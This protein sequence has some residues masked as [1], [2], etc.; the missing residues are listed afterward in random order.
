MHYFLTRSN[1][2][3]GKI[4]NTKYIWGLQDNYLNC[5]YLL[6][7]YQGIT[8]EQFIFINGKTA[9]RRKLFGQF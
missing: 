9:V 8:D 4:M 6:F 3:P 2:L 5:I 7:T 1:I